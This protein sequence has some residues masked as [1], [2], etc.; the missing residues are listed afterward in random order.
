MSRKNQSLAAISVILILSLLAGVVLSASQVFAQEEVDPQ[1]GLDVLGNPVYLPIMVKPPQDMSCSTNAPN[2][3]GLQIAGLPPI[4]AN[5]ELTAAEPDEYTL[6]FTNMVDALKQSGTGWVRLYFDWSFMEP[7]KG[8]YRWDVMDYWVSIIRSENMQIIATV[9]NPP[10]WAASYK[11]NLPCSS[12]VTDMNA[13]R[14]FLT[15]LVTRYRGW[16]S[17]IHTWE[18]M[19]EPDGIDLEEGCIDGLVNYGQHPADY[20]QLLKVGYSTIKT[21]DP[22]AKVLFGGIASDW[23]AESPYDGK[24]V[25]DFTYQV[26][27]AAPDVINS[28]DAFNFHYFPDWAGEWERWTG[29][30]PALILPACANGTTTFKP[31][32]LDLLAKASHLKLR[33]ETCSG[34]DGKEYWA[35]EVGAHGINPAILPA[36]PDCD[37]LKQTNRQAWDSN[38]YCRYTQK[39]ETLENQAR[40]VFKVYA[41]GLA[42]GLTNIEWYGIKVLPQNTPTDFQGLLYDS[43]DGA[44]NGKPKPAFYAFQTLTKE[45]PYPSFDKTMIGADQF[46]REAEAYQFNTC[47]GKTIVGWTNTVAWKDL[48]IPGAKSV[49]IISRPGAEA[50]KVATSRFVDGT[51]VVTLGIEPAI[52]RVTY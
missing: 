48:P 34:A 27:K 1:P 3:Y 52:I 28:F 31:I 40:Y 13:F 30:N 38:L 51:W 43:R 23:F 9:S 20:N 37:Q 29:S 18:L 14:N 26:I 7:Q 17:N 39:G 33:N 2:P 11:D 45:M 46:N 50:G 22:S 5:Y 16:P 41:R 32:G 21:L 24:F 47:K 12:R 10:L 25:R 6:D 49:S 36:D 42:Y 35:T 4:G 15:I 19:N 8:V 44:L